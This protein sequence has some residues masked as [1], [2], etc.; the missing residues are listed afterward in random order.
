MTAAI[1]TKGALLDEFARIAKALAAPRRLELLDLLAQGERSVDELAKVTAMSSA[2]TS[3]HLQ[4][5]RNAQL[6][7]TRRAGTR[8]HYRLA[9]DDIAELL[10]G[11]RRV[12]ANHVAVVDG[13]A[14]DYFEA[15]DELEP[16]TSRELRARVR[17]GDIVVVDVRPPEEYAAGHIPGAISIPLDD[18]EE[19][20]DELDPDTEVVA[21][22]RNRY[23]VLAPAALERLH[24]H[25]LSARRLDEGL[26]EWRAA[27]LPVTASAVA[28]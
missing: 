18:L 27:G 13:L 9:G 26:P 14:R 6:V 11:L 21:Y 15:R 16:I 28:P 1:E 2:N 17:A 25:G 7:E 4:V 23:C 8:V 3:A 10:D 12:A 5:L 19:R 20:L 22:C 24:R